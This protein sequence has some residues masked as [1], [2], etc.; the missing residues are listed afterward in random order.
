MINRV[1]FL[2]GLAAAMLAASPVGAQ[3]PRAVAAPAPI[4][5]RPA[6]PPGPAL[7]Y[8]LLSD[9][10]TLV[11]GNA[12]IF[13]HRAIEILELRP[14]AATDQPSIDAWISGPLSSIPRERALQLLNRYRGVLREVKLAV[15]RRACDWE[16]DAREEGVDL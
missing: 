15:K 13:Y 1:S 4:V 8:E 11:P 7:K 16:H 2:F 3:P 6:K 9:R 12:A 10:S 14:H 5:L